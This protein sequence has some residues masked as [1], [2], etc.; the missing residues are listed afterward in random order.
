MIFT[1]SL[2]ALFLSVSADPAR[3]TEESDIELEARSTTYAAVYST[4]KVAKTFALTYDDGPYQYE[5][6]LSATLKKANATAT[7]FVN[8]NN[9][10]CIYD[11]AD[12]IIAADKAG[13]Q[14]AQHSWSHP[15]LTK[16]TEAQLRNQFDMVE[17]ALK[18]IIGKV[19]AF[20]RPPYGAYNNLV[21]KVA[22]DYGYRIITWDLDTE[23]GDRSGKDVPYAEKQYDNYHK[24]SGP[25][26]I[27]LN[28]SPYKSTVEQVTPYAIKKLKADGY[29][30]V[31]VAEC[32]GYKPDQWYKSKT[33]PKPRNSKTWVCPKNPAPGKAA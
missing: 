26:G 4:C 33:T 23:D 9:W 27:A 1:L 15:N 25:G 5:K 12:Q 18:N 8:G 21:R 11:Q 29:R 30:L 20:M 13:H 28:H 32:L 16:L 2:F 17:T 3:M 6:E 24:A 22:H 10:A 19:P 7:F 14:I 31:S